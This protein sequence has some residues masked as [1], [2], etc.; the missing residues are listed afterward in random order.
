MDGK[1]FVYFQ[2]CISM[3]TT[4]TTKKEVEGIS[5]MVERGLYRMGSCFEQL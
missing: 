4:L 1:Y 2:G 5:I 3:S